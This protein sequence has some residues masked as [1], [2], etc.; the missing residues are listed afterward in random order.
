MTLLD[1]LEKYRHCTH[2]GWLT[3]EEALLLVHYAERTQGPLVEV[4]SYMGRSAMLLGQLG[5]PLYCVDPWADGFHDTLTG[6]EVYRHFQENI[7]KVPDHKIVPTRARVED[8][9]PIPAGFVYLDGDHTCDG[10]ARQVE[11]ALRCGPQVI[12]VHDVDDKGDGRLV[13]E[14]AV[15]LLGPWARLVDR[16]A[17][18]EI[19]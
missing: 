19:T 9:E 8:A 13:K 10:T 14:S 11:W 3:C 18:W 1:F 12:A 6:D 2:D 5:R 7:G 4:G 17:V 15:K 16:L